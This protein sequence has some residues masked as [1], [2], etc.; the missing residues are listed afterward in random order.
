MLGVQNIV[1]CEHE[2]I[3]VHNARSRSAEFNHLGAD[4]EQETN[5]DA[6]GTN[7]GAGLTSDPENGESKQFFNLAIIMSYLLS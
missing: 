4:A 2:T 7:I 6:H 5:V 1:H 3:L